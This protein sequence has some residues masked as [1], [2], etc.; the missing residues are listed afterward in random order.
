MVHY[1]FNFLY[2]ILSVIHVSWTNLISIV[3]HLLH[4]PMPCK[5]LLQLKM[6]II[7]VICITFITTL[8]LG[9]QP[10]QGLAKVQAKY[11]ARESHFMLPRVQESVRESILTLPSEFSLWELESRWIPKFS[12][13][14]CKGQNPMD[15]RVSYIIG[16]LLERRCLNW[17]AWPIWTLNTQIIAKRRVGS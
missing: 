1:L 4:I 7:F 17:R 10:R 14:D 9:L 11:E 15:W 6:N 8:T 13:S 2:I 16:K 3:K 5:R 12:K